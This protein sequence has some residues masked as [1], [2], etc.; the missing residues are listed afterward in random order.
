MHYTSIL[1]P[2]K[3]AN[4]PSFR[5]YLIIIIYRSNQ[6]NVGNNIIAVIIIRS[7][8]SYNN[9]NSNNHHNGMNNLDIH[10]NLTLIL[11]MTVIIII[12]FWNIEKATSMEIG[13][14]SILYISLHQ[15]RSPTSFVHDSLFSPST[16]SQLDRFGGRRQ[17]YVEV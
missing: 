15:L 13:S 5:L 6:S 1:H 14:W 3:H 9:N 7:E 11:I 10:G 17:E 16:K 12:I 4:N 2:Q 8:D